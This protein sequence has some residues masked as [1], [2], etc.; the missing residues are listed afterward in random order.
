LNQVQTNYKLILDRE[1]YS[2]FYF[3]HI[4]LLQQTEF[5]VVQLPSNECKKNKSFT[6]VI[7][8]SLLQ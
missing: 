6:D 8:F 2:S 5:K 3:M 1:I 4:R 7:F